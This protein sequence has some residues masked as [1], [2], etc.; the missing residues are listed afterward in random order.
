MTRKFPW[1]IESLHLNEEGVVHDKADLPIELYNKTIGYGWV[2]LDGT[3]SEAKSWLKKSSG[4]DEIWVDALL[5]T[6]TRPRLVKIDNETIFINLRGINSF[7]KEEPED[8]ISIRLYVTKQQ[9]ISVKLR[10]L[11]AITKLKMDFDSS[12]APRTTFEFLLTLIEH[13][14]EEIESTITDIYEAIDDLEEMVLVEHDKDF[15]QNVI[16]VRRQVII[17]RRYFFPNLDTLQQ[18]ATVES[19]L[20]SNTDNASNLSESCHKMTRFIEE[21]VSI[22]ERAQVIHEELNNHLTER[23]STSTNKLSAIAT[24]F[25]PMS[26]VTGLFGVNLE[27]IPGATNNKAFAIFASITFAVL[28]IQFIILKWNK[29]F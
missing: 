3:S 27:G 23:L 28:I 29:W 20:D 6:E 14:N 16:D 26:F 2:H 12:R 24:I 1:L 18:L 25:L 15:R 22:R 4:I 8:M 11:K 5:A 7:N 19:F 13:I 9:I 10:N 17:F 21:I